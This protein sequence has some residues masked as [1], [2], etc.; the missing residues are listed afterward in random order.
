L[1]NCSNSSLIAHYSLLISIFLLLFIFF[2]CATL[3]QVDGPAES[4]E[5]VSPRWTPVSVPG[6]DYFAGKVS[7]PRIEFHAL[8]VD[9]T[10]PNL[11]VTAAPGGTDSNGKTVSVKVSS[12]VRDN[13]LLAG[14]NALPFD[15][16]SETEGEPRINVGIVIA[17][18]IMLSPP[19]KSYNA[20]VFYKDGH[21]AIEAQSEI[22]DFD[23][24]EN[25]VGGFYR[26]LEQGELVQRVLD[27]SASVGDK[28]PRHP[29]SAAGISANGKYLYLLVIDGR[30]LKSIGGTRRKPPFC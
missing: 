15:T 10:E 17:N 18:S 11:R 5:A 2:S 25:A 6:L 23:N 7:R 29:R 30:Q 20:L 14:I 26:I 28:H 22:K 4:P 13:G 9:L 24:I 1:R 27:L 21:A 3:S 8:R 19:H 12:F 16:V